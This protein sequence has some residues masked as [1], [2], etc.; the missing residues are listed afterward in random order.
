MMHKKFWMP[1]G[2]RGRRRARHADDPMAV[3]RTFV[4]TLARIQ[5]QARE[6]SGE[7]ATSE[8]LP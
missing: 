5:A 4:H 1:F 8:K 7:T 3:F 2:K 6:R